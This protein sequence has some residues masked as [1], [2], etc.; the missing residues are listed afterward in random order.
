MIGK[1]DIHPA[2]P[3]ARKLLVAVPGVKRKQLCL[4]TLV[5]RKKMNDGDQPSLPPTKKERSS[6][7]ITST[8]ATTSTHATTSARVDVPPKSSVKQTRSFHPKDVHFYIEK[9]STLSDAEIYDLVCN[10][11]KPD[12]CYLFPVDPNPKRRFQHSWL[13]QYSWLAY[14]AIDNGGFCLDCLLFGPKGVHNA[15]KLQRLVSSPL[16]P[17]TSSNKKLADHAMKSKVH[18]VATAISF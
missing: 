12:E 18:E 11:W 8:P 3:V 15:S 10:V 6:P 14:S 5:L 4:D 16:L 9:A 17:S 13:T 7:T 1:V 2:P